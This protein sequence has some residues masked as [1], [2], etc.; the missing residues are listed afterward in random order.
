MTEKWSFTNVAEFREIFGTRE[1]GNGNVARRNKI[2]LE[3]LKDKAFH[4]WLVDNGDLLRIDWCKTRSMAS[5]KQKAIGLVHWHQE[6][7]ASL[8]LLGE[9]WESPDYKTDASRGL[10][11]DGSY[12]HIRYVRKDNGRVYKMKVGKMFRHILENNEAGKH[13]PEALKTWLCETFAEQWRAYAASR[14]P[15]CN[16]RTDLTFADI[17]GNGNYICE[18]MGS[19]MNGAGQDEFYDNAVNATP[20][21]LVSDDGKRILARCVIFNEVRDE[22]TGEVL[23]LA[24]RQY[25]SGQGDALKRQLVLSLINA[26]LID[27]YKAIG[28]GCHDSRAYVSNNEEDWSHRKFSIRC[29]LDDGDVLSY[30]DTFKWYNENNYTA[31]NYSHRDAEECLNT[32]DDYYH[33][34]QEEENYDEWHDEYTHNDTVEVW[35]NGRSYMCDEQRLDEFIWLDSENGY[36][37]QDDCSYCEEC[38]TYYLSENEVYSEL[39]EEYYCCEECREE[40]E[41]WYKEKYWTYSD[42]DDEYV[43]NASSYFVWNARYQRYEERMISDESLERLLKSG[44]MLFYE[45]DFY[46][47]FDA[48]LR[49]P[50]DV[51]LERL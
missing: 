47:D 44:R 33:S 49:L 24:E 3:C 29:Q 32:T 48:A 43:E 16:L 42:Y 46:Y 7:P 34:E 25:S 31:Y 45:G 27:G 8:F 19:C 23:R 6:N 10:C 1:C 9:G 14:M 17:Y 22:E 26:G 40:G 20:A 51:V 12:G 11:E 5:L 18:D 4:K 50:L 21:A 36:Y 30:Q 28:A 15:K 13:F 35:C 39:T 41:R 2:L 38:N 37:H